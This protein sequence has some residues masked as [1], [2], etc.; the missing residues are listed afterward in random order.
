VS[1]RILFVAPYTP[2]RV[3]VRTY[4]VVRHLALAGHRVTLAAL[5]DP[6]AT[7][8]I[9]DEL[10][11]LCEA[12]HIVPHGRARA[13]L[14]AVAALPTRT[15]LGAAYCHS[16]AMERLLTDLVSRGNFEVAH[17]EHLR[18]AHFSRALHGLPRVLDAVDCITELRRQMKSHG[19]LLSRFFSW[20]EWI[21]LQAYEPRVYRD[22]GRIAVTSTYDAAA[23]ASLD[24]LH[25]PPIEVIPNGVDAAYFSPPEAS[26]EPHTVL[27]SGKMSYAANDDAARFLITS[28]LPR[29]R[30]QVPDAALIIAGSGPGREL[31]RL[32]S[33]IP[34]VTLTGFVEDLRPLMAR[35]A[36]AVC[37]LRIG[38]GIQNKA[39]EAMAM[40]RPVIGTPLVS[41]ALQGAEQSGGLCT[42]P[43]PEGIADAVCDLLLRPAAARQAGEAARAYVL[44]H[45][46]WKTAAE[47]FT[48]LYDAVLAP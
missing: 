16:P 13:A 19:S 36:V 20:E 35:A 7:P 18:A 32:A 9:L 37:P 46:D 4:Q 21:K 45:H 17:V 24:P 48:R 12:V 30:S 29:I 8:D 23:L 1:R 28:I 5:E 6:F 38:V 26:P 44:T 34:C 22:F 27:F 3:R 10:N 33:R 47:R 25:L 15:P 39:L 40:A 11:T 2:S 42:A 31:R 41:R 14:S 43:D